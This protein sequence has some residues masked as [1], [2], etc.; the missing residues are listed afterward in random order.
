ME[1]LSSYS[2]NDSKLRWLLVLVAMLSTF[3]YTAKLMISP[4][5]I[6]GLTISV[7]CICRIILS[8]TIYCANLTHTALA[9]LFYALFFISWMADY[10]A[11]INLFLMVFIYIVVLSE[12]SKLTLPALIRIARI[13]IF[14][15]MLIIALDSIVRLLNPGV[16]VGAEYTLEDLSSGYKWFYAYKYN[17]VMFDDSNSVALILLP[18][19][20]LAYQI[21]K[22]QNRIHWVFSLLGIILILSCFSRSG[23]ISIFIG[24][25]LFYFRK[26]FLLLIVPIL[27]MSILYVLYSLLSN[28]GGLAA[29]LHVVELML[30]FFSNADFIRIMFGV[31]LGNATS[32]LGFTPH[33]LIIEYLI[34]SG[35]L[36][37]LAFLMFLSFSFIKLT[38]RAKCVLLVSLVASMSYYL[39]G[40][41]PFLLAPVA[42]SH[43]IDKKWKEYNRNENINAG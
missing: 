42:L 39:Y 27:L 33:I 37:T 2:N 25:S 22:D 21:Y 20:L 12:G 4:V 7:I 3:M 23:A 26:K 14:F 15:A 29:R 34:G 19:T 6:V 1:N 38:Y 24:V 30:S 8:G 17:T 32:V 18:I 13:Y 9:F 16:P 28:D 43:L 40:G 36:G 31:G 35:I 41:A 5:Y 10:S 11:L